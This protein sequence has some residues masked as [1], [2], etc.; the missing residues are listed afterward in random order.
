MSAKQV[1]DAEVHLLTSLVALL[2]KASYKPLTRTEFDLATKE[3]YMLNVPVAVDTAKVGDVFQPA[4]EMARVGNVLEC[5]A[6]DMHCC[7]QYPSLQPSFLCLPLHSLSPPHLS[8]SLFASAQVTAVHRFCP[9]S[10]P[11]FLSPQCM[12]NRHWPS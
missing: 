5:K 10:T 12:H 11:R 1:E 8:G 4:S 7:Q 3:Q 6:S 2:D 9:C